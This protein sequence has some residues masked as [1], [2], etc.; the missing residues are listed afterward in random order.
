MLT[1][2]DPYKATRLDNI[3]AR[4]E[5]DAAEQMHPVLL[6]LWIFQY[7][8][9]RYPQNLKF[10]KVTQLY[11][12]IVKQNLETTD[13]SQRTASFQRYWNEWFTTRYINTFK[14][15]IYYMSYNLALENLTQQTHVLYIWQITSKMKLITVIYVEWLC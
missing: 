15:I 1:N 13:M 12:K 5:N 8:K 14:I 7:N 2:I 6:I 10:V 3:P 9:E 4:F 11:K